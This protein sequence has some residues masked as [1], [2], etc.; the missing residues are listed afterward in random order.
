MGQLLTE[1]EKQKRS[2][3]L[4]KFV[5]EFESVIRRTEFPEGV[6]TDER[7]LTDPIG[8][9]IT[10]TFIDLDSEDNNP[11]I[12]AM[13]FTL[14]PAPDLIGIVPSDFKESAKLN[15]DVR[16]KVEN[17][18]RDRWMAAESLASDFLKDFDWEALFDGLFA[19]A[20]T[21][22]SKY[23][24]W[25]NV[26]RVVDIIPIK[27]KNDGFTAAVK[28]SKKLGRYIMMIDKWGL[29]KNMFSYF[30]GDGI[31]RDGSQTY[32]DYRKQHW[33]VHNIPKAQYWEEFFA[34][35]FLFVILHEFGH[36]HFQHLSKKTSLYD[37]M[38]MHE[39]QLQGDA[40]INL[41]L[42]RMLKNPLQPGGE[43]QEVRSEDML[44][45]RMGP[46]IR[47]DSVTSGKNLIDF[48]MNG[49]T[50][51]AGSS[52]LAFIGRS[53]AAFNLQ[54][55]INPQ[56]TYH[57]FGDFHPP[58]FLNAG[59]DMFTLNSFLREMKEVLG[60][61]VTQGDKDPDSKKGGSLKIG[62][63]VRNPKDKDW[64]VV[65]KIE[66]DG[67]VTATKWEHD[68]KLLPKLSPEKRIL[69]VK[70]KKI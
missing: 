28:K 45:G 52:D 47:Y 44:P 9:P 53:G 41:E 50:F 10:L 22:I 63:Y 2:V 46:T 17:K 4:K 68:P 65:T 61:K 24:P 25:G 56:H 5:R 54:G 51:S 58:A 16:A 12:S 39:I 37:Q 19:K 14:S 29:M 69:A 48:F 6:T 31:G 26:I 64:Y 43:T 40:Y 60:L 49:H 59:L 34:E 18:Q 13:K 11:D 20:K 15:L 38:S 35:P 70:R 27:S 1:A 8:S 23:V 3:T 66:D 57:V 7:I 36:L 33:D 67:Q 42:N 32:L 62:D 30:V 55:H 21:M